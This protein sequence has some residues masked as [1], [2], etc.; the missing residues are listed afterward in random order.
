MLDGKDKRARERKEEKR[1]SHDL[2]IVY[3]MLF[4]L[5]V[6]LSIFMADFSQTK[7]HLTTIII[8]KSIII[9]VKNIMQQLY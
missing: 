9:V 8:T 2:Y 6:L 5:W 1:N 4:C 7:L 3:G